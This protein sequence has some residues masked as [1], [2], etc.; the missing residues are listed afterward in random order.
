MSKK[1]TL[2]NAFKSKPNEWVCRKHNSDGSNQPAATFREIKKLGYSFEETDPKRWDKKLFC[3]ICNAKTTHSKLLSIEPVFAAKPRINIPNE[4]RDRILK[5]F[6]Y[7][8]AFTGASISST[9][10]I[11]HKVPFS[12]LEKDI[13]V[14]NMNDDEIKDNFQLLTGEHNLLKDRACTHC[15]NNN[16]R[17]AFLGID[18]WY[19]GNEDYIDSCDGCG[20]HDGINWRKEVSS[21]LK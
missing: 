18:F 20:W 10:E 11:D 12:R 9:P 19:K 13:D 4:M 6:N 21:K 5:L 17:P 15:I 16:K 8:D 7:T 14:S 2:L 1:D 3:P